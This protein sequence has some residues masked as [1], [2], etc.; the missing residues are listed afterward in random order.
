MTTINEA[1]RFALTATAL[2]VVSLLGACSAFDEDST[3]N[4]ASQE[5]GFR[6]GI[7]ESLSGVLLDGE[8]DCVA[9]ELA[10]SEDV[11]VGE[12]MDFA[13]DFQS[14]PEVAELYVQAFQTC[15]DP[16]AT[17]PDAEATEDQRDAMV[18]GIVQSGIDDETANCIFDELTGAGVTPR[19][20]TLSGYF[21][22][23]LNELTP[24]IQAAGAAC[25]LGG[26]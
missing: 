12:V 26:G 25:G 24:D 17:A 1:G 21:P 11:T 16:N 19:E 23:V 22:E 20:L 14:S 10:A 7:S 18:D 3:L 2:V 9:D 4:E 8:I 15:V 13:E 6:E 5:E